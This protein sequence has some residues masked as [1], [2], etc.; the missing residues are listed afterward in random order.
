MINFPGRPG[1]T[2]RSIQYYGLV[3]MYLGGSRQ[4]IRTLY[5]LVRGPCS[6]PSVQE[7]V[8]PSDLEDEQLEVLF[9]DFEAEHIIDASSPLPRS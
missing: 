1:G 9:E 7:R 2:L 6:G 3:V 5:E 8:I 4:L